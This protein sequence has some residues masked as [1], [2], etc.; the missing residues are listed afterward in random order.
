M[1]VLFHLKPEVLD[2]WRL[3]IRVVLLLVRLFAR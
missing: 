1:M 3:P 2:R